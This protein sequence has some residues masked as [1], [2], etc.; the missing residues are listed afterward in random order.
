MAVFPGP[1][2]EPLAEAARQP[3][4]LAPDGATFARIEG[5]LGQEHAL[6]SI[7]ARERT[8]DQHDSLRAIGAELDRIWE[9]LRERAERLAH[10]QPVAGP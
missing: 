5:L 2:E 10:H 4:A 8:Q 6:L 1:A 7:P 3:Q 9:R